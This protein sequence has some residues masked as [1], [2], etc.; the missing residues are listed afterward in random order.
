VTLHTAVEI[1]LN[2]IRLPAYQFSDPHAF[3][4]G[5][6]IGYKNV[7]NNVAY[8]RR[9]IN[10]EYT[11]LDEI[12]MVSNSK[13]KEKIETEIA[14]NYISEIYKTTKKTKYLKIYL[15]ILYKFTKLAPE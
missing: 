5:R 3:C 7:A 15:Y 1:K 13:Y 8:L 4:N 9:I 6:K 11:H 12:D 14:L 2:L 10:S